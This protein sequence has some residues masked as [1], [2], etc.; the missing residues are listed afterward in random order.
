MTRAKKAR[1][2][3]IY[4]NNSCYVYAHTPLLKTLYIITIIMTIKRCITR[5]AAISRT[6]EFTASRSRVGYNILH[7]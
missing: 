1:R 3:N 2:F 6:Y 7:K 5:T 4:I